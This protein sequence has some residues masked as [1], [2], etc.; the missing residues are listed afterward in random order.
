MIFF[1]SHNWICLNGRVRIEANWSCFPLSGCLS[2]R[3]AACLSVCI[4]APMRYQ[5]SFA[6]KYVCFIWW[7]K[8]IGFLQRTRFVS[9]QSIIIMHIEKCASLINATS[10]LLST[11]C[12][13]I[14]WQLVPIFFFRFL[15]TYFIPYNYF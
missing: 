13:F 12:K 15:K 11:V 3:S 9:I 14:T 6:Y 10:F 7:K 2:V 4:A 1:I 5:Y 8:K